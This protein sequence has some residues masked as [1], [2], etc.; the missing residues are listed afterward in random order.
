[1]DTITA[2]G[3]QFGYSLDYFMVAGASKRGWTTWDVGVVDS[4]GPQPGRVA[5]I[6]PIV[7]DAINFVKTIHHQ[8]R[9]YGN[10]SFALKDYTALN[11][12]IDF[13]SPAMPMLQTGI[14]PYFYKERLTMPKLIVN[15]VLD[16][17][18]QPDDTLY[19]WDGMPEP[20]R[21]LICPNAEHRCVNESLHVVATHLTGWPM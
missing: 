21:F 2:F 13:E 14:D 9:S 20:K 11:L 6:V 1:M 15:A 5:A 4:T 7:L 17:F 8:F 3:K 10:W 12:T 19:W 16:E 18:Q